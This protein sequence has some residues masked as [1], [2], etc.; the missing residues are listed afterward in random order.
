MVNTSKIRLFTVHRDPYNNGYPH[1]G[2][3]PFNPG[4]TL[5]REHLAALLLAGEGDGLELFG[6]GQKYRI[7]HGCLYS[8]VDSP[9]G[10]ET[11]K[12]CKIFNSGVPEG[13]DEN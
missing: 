9:F 1:P 11:M 12:Q 8:L 3:A 10:G 6:D 13:N 4:E 7:Y 5:S 2:R